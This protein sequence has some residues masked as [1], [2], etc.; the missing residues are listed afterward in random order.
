VHA[1]RVTGNVT[2]ISRRAFEAAL[3]QASAGA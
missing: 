3:A 1:T 2:V